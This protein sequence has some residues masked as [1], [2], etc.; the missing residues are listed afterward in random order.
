MILALSDVDIPGVTAERDGNSMTVPVV[1][2]VGVE[3]FPIFPSV[4][5]AVGYDGT[6]PFVGLGGRGFH[7][8]VVC[9][10]F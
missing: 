2:F 7:A 1:P 6:L 3:L 8:A 4:S 5:V 9:H 10:V